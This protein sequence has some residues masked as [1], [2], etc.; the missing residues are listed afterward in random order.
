MRLFCIV[1]T[2]YFKF[3]ITSG[4]AFYNTLSVHCTS[5]CYGSLCNKNLQTDVKLTVHSIAIS[6]PLPIL[7][8]SPW[9]QFCSNGRTFVYVSVLSCVYW[10]SSVLKLQ[11]PGSRSKPHPTENYRSSPG[12]T[13]GGGGGSIGGSV[14]FVAR[15]A[16]RSL[17]YPPLV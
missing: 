17:I 9:T 3:N 4:H 7:Q 10:T 12:A 16:P 11:F 8:S 14:L 5:L 15:A 6:N 13:A 1:S 2:R